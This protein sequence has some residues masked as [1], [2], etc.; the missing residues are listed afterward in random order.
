MTYRFELLIERGVRTARQLGN[1][2]QAVTGPD[3]DDAEH[4]RRD[5]TC[6]E[7]EHM[8]RVGDKRYCGACICPQRDVAAISATLARASAEL[9][10]KLR[11]ARFECP[12]KKF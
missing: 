7:C 9:T 10:N 5:A 11:R 12:K 8:V 6:N 4:S 3:C 2:V 1:F